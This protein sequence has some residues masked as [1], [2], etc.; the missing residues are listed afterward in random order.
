[1]CALFIPQLVDCHVCPL[2]TP[3]SGLSCLPSS[4]HFSVDQE[5]TAFEV[6]PLGVVAVSHAG[7]VE[8]DAPVVM[9][10]M[11]KITVEYYPFDEQI[12]P[13]KFGSWAYSGLKIDLFNLSAE[14]NLKSLIPSVEWKVRRVRSFWMSEWWF[15]PI[16]ASEAIFRARTYSSVM[17]LMGEKGK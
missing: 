13:I 14:I 16:S 2:H 1:M 9:Q 8:W 5:R 4:H 17:M 10:T 6:I 12:C 3:A 11:C 7:L 15:Y